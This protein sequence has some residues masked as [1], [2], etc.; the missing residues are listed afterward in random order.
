[1]GDNIKQYLNLG[2]P[3]VVLIIA[4]LW[5][6]RVASDET[7]V[8]QSPLVQA[9]DAFY[10]NGGTWQAPENL[11]Y[12]ENSKE[13]YF[14]RGMDCLIEGKYEQA[15]EH[16][17]KSL[18]N[19]KEDPALS[20]YTYFFINSCTAN[21]TGTGDASVITNAL[22]FLAEY[23]PLANKTNFLWEMVSTL[24]S[25]PENTRRAISLMEDYLEAAPNL[26]VHTKAWILNTIA[27]LEYTGD[28]YVRSIRR[29]YDVEILLANQP[30]TPELEYEL[31]FAQEYIANI[32]LLLENYES[33]IEMYEELIDR[34]QA[35]FHNYIS[36][37]QLAESY[38]KLENHRKARTTILE[39]QGLLPEVNESEVKEVEA[40]VHD[41]LANVFMLEG[42][43]H[44]AQLHLEQVMDYY[45][46]ND[47]NFIV[48]GEQ[49]AIIT[50]CNYLL[51]TN[52]LQ[53]AQELLENLLNLDK[54]FKPAFEKEVLMLLEKVYSE[55]NQ[56]EKLIQVYQ[57][58]LVID[59]E[60]TQ[61][62]QSAYLEFSEYYRENSYLRQDNSRLKQ[63]NLMSVLVIAVVTSSLTIFIVLFRLLITKN[64]TD[65]LTGV[66]NRKKLNHLAGLYRRRGTPEFFGVLMIDIDF[67]KLYNDSYGHMAGDQ[68]L[69]QVANMLL[70]SVRSND[71]IIRYGG[72][73]FLVLLN[74][75]TAP[76]ARSVCERIHQKLE[77]LQ[78]PHKASEI[79]DHITVSI[80]M[81]YQEKKN[82]FLLDKLIH[83]AD[84]A[85]Y[86]SK[87][88]GRNRTTVWREEG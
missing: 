7:T 39:L 71:I 58:L 26:D 42:N 28:D 87:E 54:S 2:I 15:R 6:E 70:D 22:F 46:E 69:R 72:E 12:K 76:I 44:Q 20:I 86:L 38:L 55:T 41:V 50:H 19:P 8:R 3:F 67:F 64:L 36:Y 37:L 47:D 24:V 84:Q 49:A 60:F 73:E 68:V 75:V 33:A 17:T 31:L 78:I 23:P 77:K 82:T 16:F 48:G 13:D 32:H 79:S 63:I 88:G 25:T 62:L 9:L 43:L 35:E 65:Q 27:F 51:R 4:L 61:I 53:K 10:E 11:D 52:E 5:I 80:G 40:N 85:L 66:N 18:I 74:K 29:L 59:K 81:C 14:L 57:D 34:E 45:E 30:S 21:M 83:Q 1:M 56:Q